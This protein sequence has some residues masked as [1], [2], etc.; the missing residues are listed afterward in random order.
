MLSGDAAAPQFGQWNAGALKSLD[1]VMAHP[2][3]SIN[4]PSDSL[5]AS[6]SKDIAVRRGRSADKKNIQD[7]VIED[8]T[9]L[10]S[11]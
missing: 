5:H 8:G 11:S 4:Y 9:E 7:C 3:E 10:Y 6:I 1:P 2:D